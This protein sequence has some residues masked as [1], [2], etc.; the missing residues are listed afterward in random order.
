MTD[1]L[2][3]L[4]TTAVITGFSKKHSNN[5]NTE[6]LYNA[7]AVKRIYCIGLSYRCKQGS[8]ACK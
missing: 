6:I 1:Y 2:I 3:F 8:R 7:D 4:K 5:E